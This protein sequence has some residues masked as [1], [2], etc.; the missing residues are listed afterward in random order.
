MALVLELDKD[1]ELVVDG[2]A[3]RYQEKSGRKVRLV[4]NNARD[5]EIKKVDKPENLSLTKK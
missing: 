2:A 5:V 4:I 1:Q 3:I